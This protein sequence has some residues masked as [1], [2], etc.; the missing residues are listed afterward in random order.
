[1]NSVTARSANL[2][3]TPRHTG[4]P[5]LVPMTFPAA[6]RRR[7]R[8]SPLHCSPERNGA[9]PGTSS[10]STQQRV[11][12]WRVLPKTST[13]ASRQLERRST[14]ARQRPFWRHCAP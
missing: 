11:S 12:S 7:M 1:S 9:Q 6:T 14:T 3:S 4:S 5:S 10:C 8:R 13:P 2:R